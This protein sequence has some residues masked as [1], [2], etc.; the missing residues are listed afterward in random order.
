MIWPKTLEDIIRSII[1]NKNT[2]TGR[3]S[4][5][6]FIF[7]RKDISFFNIPKLNKTSH[8]ICFKS[9]NN[10]VVEMASYFKV[11]TKEGSRI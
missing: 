9:D 5:S 6:N 11:S 10:S 4:N 1:H 7:A 3:I 2:N 8:S